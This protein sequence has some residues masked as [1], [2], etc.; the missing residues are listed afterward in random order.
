MHITCASFAYP[1]VGETDRARVARALAAGNTVPGAFVLATCLRVEV[2]VPGDETALKERLDELMGVVPVDPE[3]RE[4]DDAVRHLF[5]V[6]AGLESPIVG[7]VEVLAQFR[8]AV[9]ELRRA[10]PVEG[11]FLKILESA[12][13]TGREARATMPASPHDT[14][15]AVAAQVAGPAHRVAVIGSGTMAR[16]VVEA[17]RGLPAPPEVTLLSREPAGVDLAGAEVRSLDGIAAVL[18]ELPVVVSATSASKHL[19]GRDELSR[20]LADRSDPLLLVDMAMPP[21]FSI[22][23]GHRVH[24]VG[25]DDLARLAQRRPQSGTAEELVSAEAAETYRLLA[26]RG[27]AGPLIASMLARADDVVEETVERFAGRLS[28]D[29]DREV[30]R[31][32]AHTVARTILNRPVSALRSSGDPDLIEAMSAVF[33]DD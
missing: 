4:G 21:D 1:R 25:I 10:G 14:M 6:A 23:D 12:V 22:P 13:G 9:A 20:L 31:Q 15:A 5:R 29:G 30:L 24:Y 26:M 27:R 33:E 7:E 8:Q 19:V 32:T 28:H 17:L 16:A 3:L 11:W 18:A 2:A